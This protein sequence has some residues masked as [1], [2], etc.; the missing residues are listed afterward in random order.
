MIGKVSFGVVLLLGVILIWGAKGIPT[1]RDP[2]FMAMVE[3]ANKAP[4]YPRTCDRWDS[5][6]E[7]VDIDL[8]AIRISAMCDPAFRL[9][10]QALGGPNGATRYH[11]AW[12]GLLSAPSMSPDVREIVTLR[13]GELL[14]VGLIA[15]TSSVGRETQLFH[16]YRRHVVMYGFEEA[17]IWNIDSARIRGLLALHTIIDYGP[18][19]LLKYVTDLIG[20][21][22]P[23]ERQIP[24][25][26]VSIGSEAF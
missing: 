21:T 6:I 25:Q 8:P 23:I 12:E 4:A 5:K 3:D 10:L 14:A 22:I 24:Q 13:V 17:V 18:R 9:G 15:D 16:R 20:W 1:E 26:S 19:Y 7:E 11:A 2:A